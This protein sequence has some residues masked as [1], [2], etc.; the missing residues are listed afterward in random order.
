METYEIRFLDRQGALVL[1][2]FAQ[3]AS[4]G[5]ARSRVPRMTEVHYDHYELWNGTGLVAEGPRPQAA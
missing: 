5:D 4:D 2:Y 3:C 1:V